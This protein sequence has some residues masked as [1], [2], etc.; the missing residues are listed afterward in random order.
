MVR[1][2]AG[3]APHLPPKLATESPL[4]DVPVRAGFR[5]PLAVLAVPPVQVTVLDGC[6]PK[7]VGN[8]GEDVAGIPPLWI[9]IEKADLPQLVENGDMTNA[10]NERSLIDLAEEPWEADWLALAQSSSGRLLTSQGAK[11]HNSPEQA[12]EVLEPPGLQPAK[13]GGDS[14]IGLPITK[15]RVDDRLHDLVRDERCPS[16]RLRDDDAPFTR[17]AEALHPAPRHERGEVGAEDRV[18]A[19]LALL[20]APPAH[21][22]HI[23]IGDELPVELERRTAEQLH[24]VEVPGE[25]RPS[26]GE[27]LSLPLVLE[28]SV[29]L[30]EDDLSGMGIDLEEEPAV[31]SGLFAHVGRRP[32]EPE[33]RL[34]EKPE[35]LAAGDSLVI[36]THVLLVRRIGSGMEA[37]EV[38]VSEAV[39]GPHAGLVEN[40]QRGIDGYDGRA[41]E[42]A[43]DE[44]HDLVFGS[45]DAAL[46]DLE[47]VPVGNE[48]GDA[49]RVPR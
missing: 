38:V 10:V 30:E 18:Q 35:S 44:L 41:R 22:R 16:P 37:T 43:A 19:I 17:I 26:G 9:G 32:H 4:I 40:D 47:G 7:L 6:M 13:D 27:A 20:I 39:A 31:P 5:P 11:P 2:R 28:R 21:V 49:G 33:L 12:L 8:N 15:G 1:E 46:L 45:N 3:M 29:K 34:E 36:A 14:P 42:M 25:L 48:G 23:E 24:M